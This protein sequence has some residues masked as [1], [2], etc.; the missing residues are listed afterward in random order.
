M[1]EV[2]PGA[3]P[4]QLVPG[5]PEDV[6]RLAARM[7]RFALGAGEAAG[8]LDDLDDGAWSGESGRL[9]REAVGPVPTRLHR[10]A[11]AFTAA[12]RAL[13]TYARVLQEGQATAARA[14][15][16]VERSTPETEAADRTTA[17]GWVDRARGQV[18]EAGR[19]AAMRLTEAAADAP[20][21]GAE[22]DGRAVTSGGVTVEVVT[23]HELTDPSS[24]TSPAGDW[25]DSV[26]DVRYTQPH[27]VGFAGAAA[28]APAA[29]PRA[30]WEAWAGESTTRSLGM[31]EPGLLAAAGVAALGGLR[32][33]GRRRREATAMELVDLDEVALR[34]RR[35]EFGSAREHA[36]VLAPARAGRLR[37]ADAYRTRLASPPRPGGTVQHWAG[38]VG[39]PARVRVAGEPLGSVDREVRGAVLRTGRPPREG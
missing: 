29:D 18:E 23:R 8:R 20:E 9:F 39:G 24:L 38:P 36:G 34:R 12:A 30:A 27:D 37:S 15:Q 2:T 28:G 16:L 7:A 3:R 13:T 25:A 26:A 14:V 4:E 32:V 10:A 33:I 1:T 5:R 31:V 35:E 19:I 6:E 22:P 11:A 17:A 21:A